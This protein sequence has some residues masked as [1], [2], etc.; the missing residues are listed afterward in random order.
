M[1]RHP[2]PHGRRARTSPRARP[3]FATSGAGSVDRPLRPRGPVMAPC[4]RRRETRSPPVSLESHALGPVPDIARRHTVAVMSG[5]VTEAY[6]QQ[7]RL[8]PSAV[9]DPDRSGPPTSPEDTCRHADRPRPPTPPSG[10]GRRSTAGP[11]HRSPSAGGPL[12]RGGR[13]T[14]GQSSP[15]ART[16]SRAIQPGAQAIRRWSREIHPRRGCRHRRNSSTGQPP[17][18]GIT[19][20]FSEGH[21]SDGRPP[22]WSRHRL[23]PGPHDPCLP[24][25]SSLMTPDS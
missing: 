2:L 3:G 16:S 8:S 10:E 20:G 22:I 4:P 13:P 5:C 14:E 17:W 24:H 15:S 18:L 23:S 12:R 1:T 11:R 9:E 19:R 7:G 6:G 25:D 21:C